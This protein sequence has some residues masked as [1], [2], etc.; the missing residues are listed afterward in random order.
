MFPDLSAGAINVL[1]KPWFWVA[2][3]LQLLICVGYF[4][5]FRREQLNKP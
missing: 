3:S 4:K 5:F 2:L 1:N